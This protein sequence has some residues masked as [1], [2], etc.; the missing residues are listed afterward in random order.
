M[1][2]ENTFT[3]RSRK[4]KTKYFVVMGKLY[5]DVKDDDKH[6]QEGLKSSQYQENGVEVL[7]ST[8]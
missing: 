8:D 6:A 3:R 1:E 7:G 4:Y 2:A 5:K